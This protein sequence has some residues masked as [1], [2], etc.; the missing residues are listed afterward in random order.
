MAA[1]AKATEKDIRSSV[2]MINIFFKKN[3]PVKHSSVHSSKDKHQTLVQL[4]FF[5]S[6]ILTAPEFEQNMKL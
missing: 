3:G 5:I 6:D 2:T 4:V 1:R